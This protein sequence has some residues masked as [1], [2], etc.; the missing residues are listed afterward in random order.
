VPARTLPFRGIPAAIL[1]E[2]GNDVPNGT[3]GLLVV[4]R[5]WTS[6]TRTISGEPKR[7]TPRRRRPR[8]RK[9]RRRA[10]GDYCPTT[11]SLTCITGSRSV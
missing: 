3:G 8:R 1:D 11:T 9:S 2:L 10:P 5:P 6:L 7:F 4:K